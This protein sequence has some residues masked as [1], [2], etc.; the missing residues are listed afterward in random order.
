[1]FSLFLIEVN[2]HELLSTFVLPWSLTTATTSSF[3]FIEAEYKIIHC[4]SNK[5][6]PNKVAAKNAQPVQHP[7][8]Y[9]NTYIANNLSGKH[10]RLF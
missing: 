3:Y 5:L 9:K 10:D 7:R 4:T 6:P 8:Q 1:V 2:S